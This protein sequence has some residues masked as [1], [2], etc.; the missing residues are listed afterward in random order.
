MF[1]LQLVIKDHIEKERFKRR[2]ESL[3]IIII[4]NKKKRILKKKS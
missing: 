3:P 1:D 4:Y 2:K